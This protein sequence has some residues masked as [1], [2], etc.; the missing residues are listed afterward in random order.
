MG[1]SGTSEQT[2]TKSESLKGIL[3]KKGSVK[4]VDKT[5]ES[6]SINLGASSKQNEKLGIW[7]RIF[8]S[9]INNE[10]GSQNKKEMERQNSSLA[11]SQQ[12]TGRTGNQGK[13]G[14]KS[15]NSLYQY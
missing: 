7:F 11:S 6:V 14:M 3:S 13:K 5:G 12:P 10:A 4:K 1:D 8:S 9:C 15:K 2:V